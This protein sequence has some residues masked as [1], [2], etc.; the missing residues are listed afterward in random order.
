MRKLLS[1][2]DAR[3]LCAVIGFSSAVYGVSLISVA[4]AWI[5]AGVILMTISLWPVVKGH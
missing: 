3:D 5:V 2:V 1:S 4:A